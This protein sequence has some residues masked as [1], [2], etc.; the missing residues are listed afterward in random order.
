MKAVLGFF[1]LSLTLLLII[2][3]CTTPSQELTATV[4]EVANQV[5]AKS[6]GEENWIPA[7]LDMQ[8]FPEGQVQTSG[9]A[10]A[11][12]KLDEALVRIA[13]DSLFTLR[14]HRLQDQDRSTRLSLKLGRVWVQM[15]REIIGD[16]LF[17]LETPTVVVAVSHP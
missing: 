15:T 8:I 1:L 7:F 2:G 6:R 9:L 3:G 16:S 5:D 10:T 4:V 11:M 17:E 12:L 13:P 14:D